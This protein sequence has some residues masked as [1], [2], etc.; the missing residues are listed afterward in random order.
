MKEGVVLVGVPEVQRLGLD[1]AVQVETA[2]SVRPD[3]RRNYRGSNL[4]DFNQ[5]TDSI[6]PDGRVAVNHLELL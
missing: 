5:N 3:Q 1:E 2:D 4:L 6:F